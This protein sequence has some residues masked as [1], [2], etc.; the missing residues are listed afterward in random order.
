[1]SNTSN[2]AVRLSA[3]VAIAALW[4]AIALADG[5]PAGTNVSNT[6]TLDYSVSGVAQTQIDT[7][8]SGSNTPTE[9]TVD[10]LVDLTVASNGTTAVAPGAQDQELVF[11]LTNE[12]NDIHAYDLD[13]INDG[14]DQFSATAVSLFYHVD[15]GDGVFE[16]GADDGTPQAYD[17]G[18]DRTPDLPADRVLWVVVQG[19]IPPDLNDANEDDITLLAD[20]LIAGT[21][22]PVTADTDGNSLT[23]SAENVLADA[24]G[25]AASDDPNGGDH[26][27]SSTFIVASADLTAVKS[28]SVFS[29]D[30]AGCATIPGTPA[31]G[32]Q[33]SVPGACVE[34][35]IT[36]QNSGGTD[37]DNVVITDVLEPELSFVAADTTGF[38]GGSFANPALP[39]ANADCGAVT[40][41]VNFEGATVDA[42][43]GSPTTA[44]VI[45]RALIK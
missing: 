13:F 20:T 25:P 26:S 36:V 15:D 16:P 42:E 5:T 40:C 1:M 43:S 35:V 19:D 2:I 6:F 4:P 31:T 9:F 41:E 37:A 18:N 33:Y 44:T 12:G 24:G 32:D 14:G 8:A 10:R 34:Y 22:T 28:V 30:G 23:G 21:S 7:S 27:A 39:A 29:E 11:S 45:I 3:S 38:T 17:T